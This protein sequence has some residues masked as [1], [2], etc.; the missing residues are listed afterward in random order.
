MPLAVRSGG[1][2]LGWPGGSPPVI[3]KSDGG[4]PRVNAAMRFRGQC[5]L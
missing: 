2:T 5:L 1:V 3:A 4:R